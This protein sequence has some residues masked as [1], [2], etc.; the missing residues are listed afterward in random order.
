MGF[1]GKI[2]RRNRNI[3]WLEIDTGVEESVRYLEGIE[4][5]HPHPIGSFEI[6][7][8]RYLEGIETHR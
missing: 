6:L 4:T 5:P 1:I 7:S 3:F 2:P 8:V